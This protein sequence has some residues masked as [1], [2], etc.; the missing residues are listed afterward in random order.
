MK[1]INAKDR[2][3]E[4]N[5][6]VLVSFILNGHRFL[7]TSMIKRCENLWAWCNYNGSNPINDPDNYDDELC[8]P[9]VTHWMPLPEPPKNEQYKGLK[10]VRL[11]HF[12]DV[13]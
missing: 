4:D 8:D 7:N 9:E 6:P 10:I 13:G 11:H 3:P 2:L 1:W 12:G 5:T